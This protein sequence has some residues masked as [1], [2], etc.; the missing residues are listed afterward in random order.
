MNIFDAVIKGKQAW[1]LHQTLSYYQTGDLL[2]YNFGTTRHRCYIVE[3]AEPFE[4]V[5][6]QF[7]P[8]N[9]NIQRTANL[10]EIAVVN[11]N[12]PDT[13]FTG[14]RETLKFQLDFY[15]DDLKK[16]DVI[17]KCDWLKSLTFHDGL[18]GDYRPIRVVFGKLFLTEIYNVKNV[19]I[20]MTH[21]DGL[22]GFL[23]LR[24]TVDIN[25]VLSPDT[26]R[27]LS[28]IRKRWQS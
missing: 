19:N 4:R 17:A 18:K 23:P 6:I 1:E 26:P 16:R 25:L 27:T 9:L 10:K 21:L 24:A 13:I 12:D 5:E 22:F 2:S 11:K 20:N 3:L 7:V 14:G 8:P 15:S 28:N